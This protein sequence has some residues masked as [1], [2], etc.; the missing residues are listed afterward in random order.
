[1][2]ELAVNQVQ[3]SDGRIVEVREARGNDEMIV[4]AQLGETLG[5]GS[6]GFIVFQNC[7]VA[8][9]ID[10]IDGGKPLQLKNFAN[11]RDLMGGFNKKDWNKIEKLY[12]SLNA[13]DEV[14]N[15]VKEG[16]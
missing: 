1:M 7:M 3:L 11:Y 10:K 13:E 15:E 9:C 16:E 4:A 12:N 6:G 2:A 8:R 14:G 5:A